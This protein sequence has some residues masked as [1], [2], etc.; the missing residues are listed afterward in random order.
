MHNV[1]SMNRNDKFLQVIAVITF[2]VR[3]SRGEM[4]IDHGR[5]C[6]GLS[7]PHRIHT[8]L[9]GPRCKLGEWYGVAPSCALLG[10]FAIGAQVLL[11]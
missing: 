4:Y 1:V 3:H 5:L 8:L 9:H 7:V 2:R 11:L 10:G 6:V